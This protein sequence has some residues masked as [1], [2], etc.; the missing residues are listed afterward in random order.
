[1]RG[2]ALL[3]AAV[4]ALGIAATVDALRS[5][6]GKKPPAP[7]TSSTSPAADLRRADA[8]GV[9]YAAVRMG[10]R[11][12]LRALRLPDLSTAASF[13]SEFCEF[14]VNAAG[15]VVVGPPCP[16]D[17]VRVQ[18]IAGSSRAFPGCAPAWTPHGRLTFVLDGDVVSGDE[19]VI[20]DAT[21]FARKALGDESRLAVRQ[22]AWLTEERVAVVVAT[23]NLA[24]AVIVVVEGDRAV[25][26]P[27]RM[28]A[29]ANVGVSNDSQEIFVGGGEGGFGVQVFNRHGAFVSASRFDFADVAAVAESPDGR[30]FAV[31]RPDNV[32]IYEEADPPPRERFPVTC[33]PSDA[34]DLAWR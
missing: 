15:E 6:E 14:D 3:I 29:E 28:E 33:L 20:R 21:R 27:I 9:L 13:T 26:E 5:D 10:N 24:R 34:V 11:C 30:F 4:V 12:R 1:V 25:S 7:A 32:C 22:L 8:S 17:G 2:T 23:R 19:L 31:A 18:V 16:G